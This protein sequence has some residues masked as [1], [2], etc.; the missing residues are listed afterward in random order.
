MHKLAVGTPKNLIS[1]PVR[2][3]V[4]RQ[5]APAI[6][7]AATQEASV[8]RIL[9]QHKMLMNSGFTYDQ[10]ALILKITSQRASEHQPGQ[11]ALEQLRGPQAQ[12]PPSAPEATTTPPAGGTPEPATVMSLPQSGSGPGIPQDPA[13]G[14]QQRTSRL[15]AFEQRISF[16]EMELLKQSL[17]SEQL[18]AVFPDGAPRTAA[19]ADQHPTC[20]PYQG[21][22]GEGGGDPPL[23][24]A[25]WPGGVWGPAPGGDGGAWGPAPGGDGWAEA[26]D[27]LDPEV[28][29]IAE[30]LLIRR[31]HS[32]GGTAAAPSSIWG[33]RGRA[34]PRGAKQ[35]QLQRGARRG[36]SGGGAAARLRGR[37]AVGYELSGGYGGDGDDGDV[38]YQPNGVAAAGVVL[39]VYF[40][41]LLTLMLLVVVT[42][43]N[44]GAES[45]DALDAMTL[46]W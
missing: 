43:D 30:A 11:R 15:A 28:L 41:G 33:A 18:L 34:A 21:D 16:L 2:N 32:P 12:E 26:T 27:H 10:A 44:V 23:L 17:A 24:A 35:L 29:A 4:Q 6:P 31:G 36:G 37:G 25:A 42:G 22:P 39:A 3:A 20:S 9:Q 7:R 46:W 38:E 45:A 5:R 1:H 13:G 40:V 19:A 8:E 14:D